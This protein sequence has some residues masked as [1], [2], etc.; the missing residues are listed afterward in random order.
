MKDLF[1]ILSTPSRASDPA[2]LPTD[3]GLD[4]PRRR[5]QIEQDDLEAADMTAAD[6]E[7]HMMDIG[8]ELVADGELSFADLIE[9]ESEL[10]FHRDD[11]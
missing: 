2:F 7:A 9:L 6:F 1:L 10:G 4:I 5:L 3:E 8:A 11:S